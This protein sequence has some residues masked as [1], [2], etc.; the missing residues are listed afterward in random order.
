MNRKKIFLYVF[1]LLFL[2]F[3]FLSDKFSEYRSEKTLSSI[4][5]KIQKQN[6]VLLLDGKSLSK[7][8]KNMF[9][10]GI[11]TLRKIAYHHSS[12]INKR[13]ASIISQ[14][15]TTI[16]NLYQ[17]SKRPREFWVYLGEKE[18]G[19]VDI[20]NDSLLEILGVEKPYNNEF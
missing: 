4:K 7:N 2:G 12:R 5:G 11:M 14:S 16:L 20:E 1:A 13:T 19:R 9:V 17:D 10:E 18:V 8:Y 6:I 15:D 3:S